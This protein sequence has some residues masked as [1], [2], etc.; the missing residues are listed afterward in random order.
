VTDPTTPVR[1]LIEAFNDRDFERARMLY[2]RTYVNHDP[3]PIAAP[4]EPNDGTR[5]IRGLAATLPD[6]HCEIVQCLQ[7]GKL[8]VLHTHV[9]GHNVHG[10]E[11]AV[12]FITVFRVEGGLIHESWGLVDAIELM[13]QLGL[14]LEPS[15]A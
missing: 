2:A 15:Q 5:G 8:V 7:K 10:N 3:L 14:S 4:G 13:R 11:V 1:Q 6:S 12:E 9:E